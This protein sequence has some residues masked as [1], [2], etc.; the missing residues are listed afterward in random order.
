MMR[1]FSQARN[2][3]PNDSIQNDVMLQP[4]NAFMK[5]ANPAIYEVKYPTNVK[6][7][8]KNI[9]FQ[10]NVKAMTPTHPPFYQRKF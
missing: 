2:L 6:N 5:K 9:N 10:F 4:Q 1:S 7:G 8:P 3:A